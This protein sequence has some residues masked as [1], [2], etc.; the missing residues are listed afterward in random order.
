LGLRLAVDK[1][2]AVVFKA[3]YGPADL[4]LRIGD[5][6]VQMCAALNYLGVVHEAKGMWYGAHYRAAADK[7]RRIMAALRGL[8]PNAGVPRKLRRRLLL[9]VVHSVMLYGVPTWGADFGL[10]RTGPKTLAL[11]QRLAAI[12]SVSAYRTASYDA[13]TV[14]T[15]TVPIVLMAQERYASFE[16]RRAMQSTGT[17]DKGSLPPDDP[18][19]AALADDARS[20]RDRVLAK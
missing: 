6:A 15:R 2:E 3:Q 11:V 5:Q 10:S 20:L 12:S 18:S 16:I 8:M 19:E 14:V 4:S 17:D 7:A 13:V 1:T 9:S